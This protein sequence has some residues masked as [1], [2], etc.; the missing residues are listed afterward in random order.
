MSLDFEPVFSLAT[1]DIIPGQKLVEIYHNTRLL[2]EEKDHYMA[3][4]LLLLF[5]IN[6][7][8]NTIE[9]FNRSKAT[10]GQP[11]SDFNRFIPASS[12]QGGLATIQDLPSI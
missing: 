8:G 9:Y 1:Y 11:Y 2:I 6:R 7:K 5:E 3:G 10:G 4:L 12:W